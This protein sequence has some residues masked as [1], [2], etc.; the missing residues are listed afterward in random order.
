MS[1]Q[2]ELRAL[3]LLR[4]Q[5]PQGALQRINSLVEPQSFVEL[6][7]FCGEEASGEGLRAGYEIGRALGKECRSRWS[8]YH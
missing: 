8:P 3:A 4:S 5:R 1:Y 6:E 7:A 2:E